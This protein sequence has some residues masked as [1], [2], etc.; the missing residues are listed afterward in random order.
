MK[1]TFDKEVDAA[2]IYLK[3][4]IQKGEMKNTIMPQKV[5]SEIS[6]TASQKP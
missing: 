1:M 2:Y 6:R 3:D 4:K 5:V